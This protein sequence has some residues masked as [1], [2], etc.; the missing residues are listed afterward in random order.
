VAAVTL[1][2]QTVA[3]ALANPA[4]SLRRE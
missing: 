1:S 2:Y 3:A 4:D